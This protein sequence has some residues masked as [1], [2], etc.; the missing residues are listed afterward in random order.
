[1]FEETFVAELL[2]RVGSR[3]EVATDEQFIEGVL[4]NVTE[5]FLVINVVNGYY[6]LNDRIYVAVDFINF[7]RFPVSAA[8]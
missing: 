7:V 4:S 6:G 1:M 5:D 3:I 8:V 2:T